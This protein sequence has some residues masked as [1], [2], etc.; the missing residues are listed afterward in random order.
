MIPLSKP[1]GRPIERRHTQ[2]V[3]VALLGRFMRQDRTESVCQTID[4][5]P[6][7]AAFHAAIK[8]PLG[9][10]IVAYLD[11]VGRLEGIVTRHLETGFAIQM[12]TSPLKREKLAEQLTWLANRHELGMKEDRRHDRI[13]PTH[14]RT[15]LKIADGREYLAKL[16]DISVSG[17]AM[18][19]DAELVAGE[20]VTVGET[21]AKVVRAFKGGIA[22]EFVR[23]I[24]E[25]EFGADTKL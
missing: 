20:P 5:S 25:A 24:P 23:M 6:G 17:A 19:V 12:V 11:Q 10:R 2:R 18:T 4:M 7:S 3:K 9:E 13:A 16:V 14:A 15:T 1:E 21:S 22:V 8:P